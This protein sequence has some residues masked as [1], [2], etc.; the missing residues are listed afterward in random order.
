MSLLHGGNFNQ[1][2]FA[3]LAGD[4]M[5]TVQDS[6][7]KYR[8]FPGRARPKIHQVGPRWFA[9]TGAED[10]AAECIEAFRGC[11]ELDDMRR[12]MAAIAARYRK[13]DPLA[14]CDGAGLSILVLEHTDAEG[15]ILQALDAE[16]AGVSLRRI[17]SESFSFPG[18]ETATAVFEEY[19][20][21][22]REALSRGAGLE[23]VCRAVET[24][25]AAQ[26]RVSEICDKVDTAL[27]LVLLVR[28]WQEVAAYRFQGDA[29][30]LAGKSPG[31]VFGKLRLIAL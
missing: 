23:T 30:E 27:D 25:A 12:E 28:T 16:K 14:S 24:V 2:G 29:G 8:T 26:V 6:K 9:T 13:T 1:F 17:R 20:A 18:A 7:G 19:S 21:R 4:R 10:P 22:M 5:L 11:N 15:F 3:L 31:E